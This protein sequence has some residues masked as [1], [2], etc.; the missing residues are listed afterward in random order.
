M[1]GPGCPADSSRRVRFRQEAL[2]GPS[3]SLT[4]AGSLGPA[5]AQAV[6]S[7]PLTHR[8]RP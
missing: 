5:Q 3:Y 6:R 2:S 8:S 4:R 1:L 7:S